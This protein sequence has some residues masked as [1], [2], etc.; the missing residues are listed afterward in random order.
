M[1]SGKEGGG[2]FVEINKPAPDFSSNK[3]NSPKCPQE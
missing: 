2:F 1:P 3:K